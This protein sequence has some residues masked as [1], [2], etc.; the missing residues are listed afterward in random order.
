M[1]SGMLPWN[2][3]SDKLRCL[4][5]FRFDILVGMLPGGWFLD[6]SNVSATVRFSICVGG[7]PVYRVGMLLLVFLL[8]SVKNIF[9]RIIYSVCLPKH[10]KW[11]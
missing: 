3:L 7:Y 1:P 4:N 11:A 5:I 6:R 9:G 8:G 2:A 10:Y